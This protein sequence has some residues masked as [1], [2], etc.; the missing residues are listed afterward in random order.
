[1]TYIAE[2][3]AQRV[4]FIDLE[5]SMTRKVSSLHSRAQVAE[6]LQKLQRSVSGTLPVLK[7]RLEFHLKRVL[8]GLKDKNVINLEPK[9]RK[10]TALCFATP[11][12]LICAD[13][14]TRKVVQISLTFDGVTVNGEISKATP[15]PPAVSSVQDM[16]VISSAIYFTGTL[17]KTHPQRPR[18]S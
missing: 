18:G 8:D 17:E 7:K 2:R 13:D 14:G 15:Y 12:I 11:G 6:E 1:M 9:L 10:P 5:G 4:R 16:T 3:G